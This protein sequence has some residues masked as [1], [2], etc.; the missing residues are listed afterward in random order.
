MEF[1]LFVALLAVS[2]V[3][4]VIAARL[5]FWM[6]LATMNQSMRAAE[7]AIVVSPPAASKTAA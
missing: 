6:L 7:P 1:M 3:L 2:T 4:G 5:V